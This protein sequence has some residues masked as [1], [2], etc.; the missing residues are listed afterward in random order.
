M[1]AGV[2]ADIPNWGTLSRFST[3]AGLAFSRN[4]YRDGA[5]YSSFYVDPE[6]Q[7]QRHWNSGYLFGSEVPFRYELRV[8]AASTLRDGRWSAD[9]LLYSDPRFPADFHDRQDG[10]DFSRLLRPTATQTAESAG[11]VSSLVWRFSGAWTPRV[12]G[13]SPWVESLALTSATTELQWARRTTQTARL[14]AAVAVSGSDNSPEAEFF[15]PVT[16]V[17][18]DLRATMR[19]TLWRYPRT[20]SAVALSVGA[21]SGCGRSGH[22]GFGHHGSGHSAAG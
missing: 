13:L 20:G 3:R 22:A 6:G 4:V 16:A 15:Y 11:S 17:T 19:G 1:Y 8:N 2:E 14:P 7:P 10:M 9:V 5:I 21:D 18:P 12:P